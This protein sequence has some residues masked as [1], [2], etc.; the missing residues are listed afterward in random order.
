MS[1]NWQDVITNLAVVTGGGTVLVGASAWLIK[2]VITHR[3]ETDAE[4]FRTRIKADADIEIERLKS[5][6]QIVAMEHQVRFTKLHEKRA[7]IIADLYKKLIDLHRHAEYFVMTRENNS[8]PAKDKEFREIQ[9][10]MAD[11]QKFYQEHQIYLPLD[12]CTSLENLLSEITG[13]VWA[14]GIFGRIEHPG[15]QTV[16]S[17]QEAFTK[18]Y[19]AFEEKIP[20]ARKALE[21]EFRKMLGVEKA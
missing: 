8:D 17:S 13:N 12:V 19:A 20:A 15:E 5:S 7:E 4:T 11:F 1:I 18:G 3:L 2:T 16:L 21:N 6:L 14:A 10:E 9:Q